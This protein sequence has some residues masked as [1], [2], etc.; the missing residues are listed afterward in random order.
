MQLPSGPFWG[1]RVVSLPSQGILLVATDLH[2]NWDDYQRMKAVY[3]AEEDAGGRPILLF[4]GDLVHGPSDDLLEKG[5]WPSYL[6]DPYP[7]RS[8]EVIQDYL[9]FSAHARTLSLLGN[10]EHAHIG[11]PVLQKFHP[12]EAAVLRQKL[13]E[14]APRIHRFFSSFPLLVLAP[15]GVAFTHAA[16]SHTED[17]LEAFE[18]LSYSGFETTPLREIYRQGTVGALLWS[19]CATPQEARCFLDSVSSEGRPLHLVVFG[20]DIVEDG[21]E[22]IGEE[23]LCLSTSFG[24]F[25]ERKR[26]LRLDLHQRYTSV[27]ELRDGIEILPLYPEESDVL[28]FRSSIADQGGLAI[29]GA[30]SKQRERQGR[31]DRRW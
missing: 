23:Q 16:P 22:K 11:G 27:G 19:R 13:G 1:R 3:Q 14:A 20:H 26:Y 18:T 25:R 6:G 31:R 29:F 4:C 2:G 28:L 10:H 7:D 30:S 12:D 15:C 5:A 24:L 21:Y 9:G 8:A 17:S